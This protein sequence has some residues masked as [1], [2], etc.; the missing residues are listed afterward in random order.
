MQ[1]HACSFEEYK[2]GRLLRIEINGRLLR[3]EINGRL[4][5]I[6]INGRLTSASRESECAVKHNE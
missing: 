1:E 3:I 2:Y 5:R 4:L 6:E